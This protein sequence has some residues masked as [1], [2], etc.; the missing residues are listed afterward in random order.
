[1]TIFFQNPL[2]ACVDWMASHK[3]NGSI[4]VDTR[5]L[6]GAVLDI[7]NLYN[8][9]Y[10]T[11]C[12]S[13][14][15]N[16]TRHNSPQTIIKNN[17]IFSTHFTSSEEPTGY[18]AVDNQIVVSFISDQ[19]SST[20]PRMGFVKDSDSSTVR[21]YVNSVSGNEQPMETP[22]KSVRAEFL[23]W[24]RQQFFASLGLTLLGLVSSYVTSFKESRFSTILKIS[25]VIFISFAALRVYQWG[26]LRAE[27]SRAVIDLG[28]W[29]GYMRYL[30]FQCPDRVK[31][32]VIKKFLRKNEI[33]FLNKKISIFTKISNGLIF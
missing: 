14:I 5:Y 27:W 1:M 25:H 11:R 2:R 15:G 13:L 26:S 19:G 12:A 9:Y 28:G 10:K 29:A 17:I 33:D 24:S 22:I 21:Q 20:S 4:K 6:K 30:A 18:F 3:I 16:V 7:E 23:A 31:H 8:L 32:G